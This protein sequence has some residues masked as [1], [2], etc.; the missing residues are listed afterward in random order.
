MVEKKK[1]R[2]EYD[3]EGCIGAGPCIALAPDFFAF[4]NESKMSIQ[5]EK[6]EKSEK[7]ESLV[8]ELNEKE[9]EY[10][11]EAARVCPVT[12]IKLINLE[13]NEEV[14]LF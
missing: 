5:H 9:L 2:I 6:A 10:L 1:Y 11:K 7:K 8:L 3:R 4:D 14:K 12:V 13:T